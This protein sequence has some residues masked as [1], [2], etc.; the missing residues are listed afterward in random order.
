MSENKQMSP[1]EL[2]RRLTALSRPDRAL[3]AEIGMM[4]GYTRRMKN[5]LD[6]ET[7]QELHVAVWESPNGDEVR[8]PHFTQLIHD[9]HL[10]VQTILPLSIGGASWDEKGG[11]ARIDNGPYVTA[12]NSAIAICIAALG[13]M[14]EPDD[15]EDDDNGVDAPD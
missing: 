10:L 2:V 4:I 8:M 11:A 5:D 12:A 15:L 9:A 1:Q 7:G 13:Q 6:P 3:D 14:E